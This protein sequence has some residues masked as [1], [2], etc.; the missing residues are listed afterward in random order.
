MTETNVTPSAKAAPPKMRKPIESGVPD[1]MQYMHPVMRKNYGNWAWHER[2]RPGVLRHVAKNGDEI[3]TVRAG[4]QRQM[5][6]YTIRKLCDIGDQH[7]E[8]HVR[9]T[10]RS[11]IE[12]MVA[13]FEKVPALIKA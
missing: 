8:G 2:P 6:V 10:T 5:D 7:G 4:T 3:F 11:N 13:S 9:F 1:P 12:F